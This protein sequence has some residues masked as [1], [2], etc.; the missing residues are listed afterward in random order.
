MFSSVSL[1]L[2]RAQ[3]LLQFYWQAITKYQIHSPFVAG[4]VNEVVEDGRHFYAFDAIELL[5]E[6]VLQNG[7][8]IEV[9]DYGTG[10]GEATSS[11]RKLPIRQVAARSG[12]DQQ[13]GQRLFKLAN[14]L[15]PRTV[16]ELGTSLGLGTLYLTAGSPEK[17]RV[18][19][20]E[21]CPQCAEIAR[22]HL[23]ML[24]LQ[25]AEVVTGPFS[26]TLQPVAARLRP[27]DLVFFDGNHREQPTLEY[28]QICLDNAA[29][30]AVLVFDDVH[31]SPGMRRAWD[32]VR[33]HP[34]VTLTVDCW[35]FACAFL[36]PDFKQKQHLSVVPARWKPW[37]FF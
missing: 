2:F 4:L 6:Q 31:W 21:G 16:L 36:N 32:A 17:A 9:L 12:S 28:F 35:D 3:Q 10:A 25:R 37:R 13:Q 11:R 27:L 29:P 26:D 34:R 24:H 22:M 33:Q 23:E 19:S 20:L 14:F 8:E 30:D 7:A 18:V 1:W 15:Q 5:R